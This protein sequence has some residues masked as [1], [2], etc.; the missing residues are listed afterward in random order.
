VEVDGLEV[1]WETQGFVSGYR[2]SDA[3]RAAQSLPALA[4]RNKIAK[5]LRPCRELVVP[6]RLG[7]PILPDLIEQR[8]VADL[9]NGGGLLAVPVRLI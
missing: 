7:D 6:A 9:K 4:R 2:F 1:C 8:L 3:A 5:L